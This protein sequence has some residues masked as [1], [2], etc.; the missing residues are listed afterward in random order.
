MEKIQTT[1]SETAEREYTYEYV[2]E[3]AKNLAAIE[4]QR[5]KAKFANKI[6]KL[7]KELSGLDKK[8]KK[9]GWSEKDV[10]DHIDKIIVFSTT[11]GDNSPLREIGLAEREL[12]LINEYLCALRV[13]TENTFNEIRAGYGLAPLSEIGL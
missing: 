1:E 4:K 9:P 2:C 7:K 12:Q 6:V 10:K 5:Q 3:L 11:F 13:F 8:L